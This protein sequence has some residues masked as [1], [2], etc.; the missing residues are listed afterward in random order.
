MATATDPNR[1]STGPFTTDQRRRLE[2]LQFAKR[3]IGRTVTAGA[4][5]SDTVVDLTDLVD[6]A[7]YIVSGDH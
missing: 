7:E 4:Y 6:L 5:H 1:P 2:A 3:L